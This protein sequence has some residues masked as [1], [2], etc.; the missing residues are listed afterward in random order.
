MFKMP[1]GMAAAVCKSEGLTSRCSHKRAAT[2]ARRPTSAAMLSKVT[3]AGA[4]TEVPFGANPPEAS[5]KEP[6][7]TGKD[8]MTKRRKVRGTGRGAS[9]KSRDERSEPELLRKKHVAAEPHKRQCLEPSWPR[10]FSH[11]RCRTDPAEAAKTRSSL[12]RSGYEGATAQDVRRTDQLNGLNP[13]TLIATCGL[14]S[15]VSRSVARVAEFLGAPRG[16][17]WS[18]PSGPLSGRGKHAK[19]IKLHVSG[20]SSP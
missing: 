7:S 4:S 13:E 9:R 12:N 19:K 5:G 1:S 15:R 8:A 18:L 3:S 10:M 20:Q 14:G 11:Q 17:A 6:V 2:V 16:R